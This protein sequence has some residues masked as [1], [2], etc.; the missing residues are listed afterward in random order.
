MKSS[1]H[2]HNNPRERERKR[3]NLFLY[4]EDRQCNY[5]SI[6]GRIFLKR[7]FDYGK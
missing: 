3:D 5:L 4:R 2:H 6:L 1:R 7:S